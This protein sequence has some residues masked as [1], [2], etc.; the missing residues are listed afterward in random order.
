MLESVD[1]TIAGLRRV[2][3]AQND[4]ELA[5][6]LGIDKSTVSGWRARGRVPERFV[7]VLEVEQMPPQEVWPELH[8]RGTAVALARYA[9]MRNEAAMSGNLDTALPAFLDVK[10]FWLVMHRAV[11]DL[12]SKMDALHV[13]L[14]TA[15]ALLLQEDLR[16]PQDTAARV[17]RMLAEDLADSP[18]LRDWK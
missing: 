13:D 12:R 2:V 15:A 16:A 4:S 6:K 9:I 18:H 5:S 11:F 3:G 17:A 7:K 14:Q 10:P 1:S 8:D